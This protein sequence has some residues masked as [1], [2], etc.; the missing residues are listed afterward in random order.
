MQWLG[1]P[2]LDAHCFAATSWWDDSRC[3]AAVNVLRKE[4]LRGRARPIQ[5]VTCT[6][7]GL[8]LDQVTRSFL[9]M[10]HRAG[11]IN[12][13]VGG[14]PLIRWA[15]VDRGAANSIDAMVENLVSVGVEVVRERVATSSQASIAAGRR[16]ALQ[17]IA[18]LDCR[19]SPI[20]ALL[21]DD[22]AFDSLLSGPEG[23]RCAAA[24]PW[25]PALWAYHA[26]HP[27]VD[28]ALGGVTG[29][30]PLP[31]SSTLAT[32]L[33]DVVAA[34][35][36]CPTLNT[37]ARWSEDD[38]YYDLSPVRTV[39]EPYPLLDSLQEPASLIEALMIHGTLARPLVATPTS[40]VR[41]RSSPIVRGGNTVVFNH[42]LLRLPH[43]EPRLGRLSLRRA[44]TVWVQAVVRLHRYRIGQLAWPLRH[45]RE[46]RGWSGRDPWWCERLLAD[47]GGVGLYR[48]LDRWSSN[49]HWHRSSDILQA[50][51][52]VLACMIDRRSQVAATLEQA[53][54]LSLSMIDRRPE[55]AEVNATI[56][57]GIALVENLQLDVEPISDLLAGL[58][59]S[60]EGAP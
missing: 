20:V 52:D 28:V 38:Y 47:L 51:D 43:P 30:P 11:L 6:A 34:L 18:R 14:R 27:D 37:P 26:E 56:E 58:S 7:G 2:A 40:I 50:R 3:M 42:A 36:G 41:A 24:W 17:V 29:A 49:G 1:I 5:L 21:D 59:A 55:F 53:R 33:R 54:R 16:A 60:L 32:N 44:D 57:R 15:I 25:L 39:D 46:E 22:L 13:R 35:D 8:H 4:A 9:E 12:A 10:I 48:G 31:A 23:I 19:D 45:L